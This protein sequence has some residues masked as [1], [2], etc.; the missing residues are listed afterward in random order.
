MLP[1]GYRLH[2]IS[3]GRGLDKESKTKLDALIAELKGPSSSIISWDEQPLASLQEIF[4]QQ[5]LPAVK[6]PLKFSSPRQPYT[7]RSGV[8]DCY[9][10][11]VT[12]QVLADLYD[13][14]GEGLLQRNIRVDQGETATNKA[15]EGTCVGDD[16]AN[17]LHFNNGV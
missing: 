8:A 6:D 1:K 16:S 4:Y 7:V 17:F 11:H 3:S 9:L 15:I 12:G 2:F 10:F 5:N 13:K 14:H